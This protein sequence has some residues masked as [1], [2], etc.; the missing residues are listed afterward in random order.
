MVPGTI[1]WKVYSVTAT[2]ALLGPVF[3]GFQYAREVL[4]TGTSP[5]LD[6][7]NIGGGQYARLPLLT[8]R[9]PFDPNI[10]E[11]YTLL[12]PLFTSKIVGVQ[13]PGQVDNGM[14]I[15]DILSFYAMIFCGATVK[16]DFLQINPDA[17]FATTYPDFPD[18]LNI[19]EIIFQKSDVKRPAAQNNATIA[20]TTFEKILIAI[21][22]AYNLW[23]RITG[24]I[25]R[26]EHVS[27]FDRLVSLNLDQ[28]IYKRRTRRTRKYNYDLDKIP[29]YERFTFMEAGSPDFVG[30]PIE[31]TGECVSTKKDSA[32]THALENI[33]TD[34]EYIMLNADP[35][36][37]KVSDQGF[38][39]VS[40][41]KTGADYFFRVVS[42]IL[43]PAIHINNSLSWAYLH[44]YFH[45]WERLQ[46]NGYINGVYQTFESYRPTKKRQRIT[47]PLCC[48]DAITLTDKVNTEMGVARVN[49]AAFILYQDEIELELIYLDEPGNVECLRPKTFSFDH[50]SGNNFYFLTIFEQAAPQATET[51]IVFPDA[52]RDIVSLV[53]DPGGVSFITAPSTQNGTYLFRKRVVCN[54]CPGPWTNYVSYKKTVD[55]CSVM[56]LADILSVTFDNHK[57]RFTFDTIID[58][59][60]IQVEINPPP[61]PGDTVIVGSIKQIIGTDMIL[62]VDRPRLSFLGGPHKFRFRRVCD[63]IAGHYA[64]WSSIYTVN[65]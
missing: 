56:N 15:N 13:E 38:A 18:R 65:L 37:E 8:D 2:K 45:A 28:N 59:D 27:W 34:I 44:K 24:N 43:E 11:A 57:I 21:C 50:R 61:G 4:T 64:A 42:P 41:L 10:S 14:L 31:Y 19:Y 1:G 47:I 9:Q 53:S 40:A 54:G 60:E 63:A 6:W 25:F 26:I 30:M 55:D 51:E 5:G 29:K 12:G 20:I 46:K 16:S 62:I 3:Y 32:K 33:S 7:I 49:A 48:D 52:S 36:S 35:K 58:N 22:R 23:Y 17:A 39:L